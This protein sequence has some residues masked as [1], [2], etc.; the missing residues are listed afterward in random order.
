MR[1]LIAFIAIVSVFDL[2][3][4]DIFQSRDTL[5]FSKEGYSRA[6]ALQKNKLI[7]GTSKSGVLSYDLKKNT[8]QTI[9]PPAVGGE[10]R[11]VIVNG[12]TV[13]T[14]LSGDSG[15]VFKAKGKNVT[16]IFRDNSFIDDIVQK[17]NGELILLSDPVDN[18]L[19]IKVI[20][21]KKK[22]GNY[23]NKSGP[24]ETAKGEAYYAASGTT[25]QLI[26][27]VYY[28]IS[29]GPNN[30]TFYRKSTFEYHTQ[31]QT[32]LPMPKAE[33]AGPF[34]I[35]MFDQS[36]GVIVG[37]NYTKPNSSDS[38]SVYTT[39]GGKTW[40]VSEIPTHGYRSCVTGT[41]N[42]LFACGTNGIDYSTDGGKTW[43]SIDKGNYCALLLD[44]NVLYATTNKGYVIRFWLNSTR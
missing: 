31:I 8:V 24:F 18:K 10:F 44:G 37:G 34:S 2:F 16:E 17:A 11:D 27:G 39:D 43:I 19:T 13:Y 40:K 29:G 5:F 9:I 36:N 1:N 3:G 6:I 23:V 35:C 14:C 28:Y 42:R 7:I 30:A 38:T 25:A 21:T 15:V 12:K 41:Q 4:Q 26:G 32:E 22:W 20:G 33:G